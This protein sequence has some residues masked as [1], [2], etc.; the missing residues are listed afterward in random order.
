MKKILV[1]LLILIFVCFGCSA[2]ENEEST[3]ADDSRIKSVN[4]RTLDDSELLIGGKNVLDLAYDEVLDTWGEP[5]QTKRLQVKFPATEEYSYV[6]VLEY[7]DIDIEMYPVGAD[8]K[9]QDTRSFR[10]DITGAGVEFQGIK[11]GGELE[12]YLE[13]LSNKETLSVETILG[14]KES[15]RVPYQY[16]KL[17]VSLKPDGYYSGYDKAVYEELVIEDFP[18]GF[19]VLFSDD[20]ISRIVYGYPNAS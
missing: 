12:D 11:I 9:V 14:D 5:N 17:L 2:N 7:D 3:E 1:C 6:Y 10:F 13:R 18:Y 19:V 4:T 8:T 16:R 20:R 15:Q